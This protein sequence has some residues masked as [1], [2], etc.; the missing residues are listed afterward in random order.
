MINSIA[1]NLQPPL[2]QSDSSRGAFVDSS[3]KIP[4]KQD[5]N[6]FPMPKEPA[7]LGFKNLAAPT[8]PFSGAMRSPRGVAGTGISMGGAVALPKI[9][10][11]KPAVAG[12]GLSSMIGFGTT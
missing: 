5:D 10:L 7:G 1:G 11:P 8:I 2:N 12:S 4:T 6:A 9:D 3:E